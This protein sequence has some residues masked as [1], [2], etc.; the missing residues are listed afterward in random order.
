MKVL[1]LA[2]GAALFCGAAWADAEEDAFVEANILSIF[3]HE[4]GHAVIDLMEVP[5]FGQEEDA[6]DVMAVLLIDWLFEEE[7]AQ[8]IAYDRAF[9][10]LDDPSGT[11]EVAYWD[12][13]GP[14]EQRYFNHVCL[15]YGADPE[16]RDGLAE[17]LGLPEERAE[18]CAEEYDLAAE[19]W[20]GV[21]DA[22]EASGGEVPMVFV[23]EDDGIAGRVIAAEVAAMNAEFALP[24]EVLVRVE[25]CGEANAFYDPE[26]ISIT[27]CAEFVPHLRGIFA[28]LSSE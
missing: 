25:A 14:D 24:E 1:G 10:Y 28:S 12:L 6:A 8:A 5:I 27:F 11:E 7:A 22:M 23:G 26:D 13:H 9:G 15:F 20:G 4:L 21:F 2:V 19:S 16:A 3:Y 18:T 17:D